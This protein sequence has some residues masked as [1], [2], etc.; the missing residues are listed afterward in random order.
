[1]PTLYGDCPD[2]SQCLRNWYKTYIA[3]SLG[4]ADR[5]VAKGKCPDVSAAVEQQ[6]KALREGPKPLTPKQIAAL[7]GRA[8]RAIAEDGEAD[9][10]LSARQCEP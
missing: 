8:Y 1:M 6:I 5:N 2:K 10:V 4:T 7:S 3:L 9:P